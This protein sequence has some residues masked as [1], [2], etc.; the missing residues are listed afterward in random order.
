MFQGYFVTVKVQYLAICHSIATL[1]SI[2]TY[3]CFKPRDLYG[4][5]MW[6]TDAKSDHI[7]IRF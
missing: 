7:K 1:F 3:L 2:P 6:Q 5:Q 4:F